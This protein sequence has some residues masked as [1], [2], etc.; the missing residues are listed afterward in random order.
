MQHLAQ[1]D[2]AVQGSDL[3]LDMH[4]ANEP[5]ILEPQHLPDTQVLAEGYRGCLQ[6]CTFIEPLL[7]PSQCSRYAWHNRVR[8]HNKALP[9]RPMSSLTLC[10]NMGRDIACQTLCAIVLCLMAVVL[11]GPSRLCQ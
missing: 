9:I 11:G 7:A 8:V 3:Q 5:N 1:G 4:D 6:V 2:S 10:Q